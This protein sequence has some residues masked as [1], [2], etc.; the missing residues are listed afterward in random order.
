MRS[1]SPLGLC[2]FSF[3]TACATAG[4][5]TRTNDDGEPASDESSSDGDDDDD[6]L[7]S[8]STSPETGEQESTGDDETTD[9]GEITD[10]SET[11]NAS[12]D[13]STGEID[14]TTGELPPIDDGD[15]VVA[16]AV[17]LQFRATADAPID[18]V[19]PLFND[20]ALD[21]RG[22]RYSD[23]I[24]PLGDEADHLRFSIV[25][26]END[27]YLRVTLECDDPAVRAEVRDIDDAV[28][29]FAACGAGQVS[30][31]LV[32]A[33]STEPYDV[34]VRSGVDD[35]AAT[36][37]SVALDAFCFGGCAYQPIEA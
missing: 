12:D 24:D 37:Y 21:V 33:T 19:G 15:S 18:I 25:P 8:T 16:P 6:V 31:L 27:P 17:L 26:G 28:V 14:M 7:P 13:A 22:A 10:D 11:T 9:E 36:S 30:I 32:G 4:N 1:H 35:F 34:V 5:D 2:L 23:T 29:G 3:L 20:E